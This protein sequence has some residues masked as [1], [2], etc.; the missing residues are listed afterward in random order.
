[1]LNQLRSQ[2][3]AL[4]SR[5]TRTQRLVTGALLAT[6]LALITAFTWW[7]GTPAYGVAFTGLSD[8][9]A[10]A[11]VEQLKSQSIP[12]KLQSGGVILVPASEV[13]DVRL[14]MANEGLPGN[15]TVGFELFNTNSLGLTEFT[16]KVNYQRALEGELARTI[17]SLTNV[18]SARV[19]L[20]IPE[21]AL[22]PDQ[23]KQTTASITVHLK[24]GQ[25]LNVNQVEAIT[26][27]VASSI[28][29]LDPANVVIVDS[30]GQLLSAGFQPGDASGVSLSDDQLAA[31]RQ[32]ETEVQT[33]VQDMLTQALGPNKA[34]VRVSAKLN[35]DQ[36]E[37]TAQT[38]DA[39]PVIRSSS[40][41]TETYTGNGSL[42]GG[43]PGTDT[44]LPTDTTP[45]YQTVITDTTGTNYQ[46][47]ET[48][49]NFEI[50]SVEKHTV[51]APGQVDRLSVS[52]LVD[53]IT[54]QATLDTLT[55]V[56]TMAAGADET[57]GDQI[58]VQSLAF[59]RTYYD[60]QT[61]DMESAEQLDL[62]I[63]IGA[64]IAAVIVVIA[65]LW[66]IQRM[67]SNLRLSAAND[68]WTPLLVSTGQQ[69]AL[70]AIGAAP[71]SAAQPGTAL[72]AGAETIAQALAHA[73]PDGQTA[74]P[75]PSRSPQPQTSPELER[76][77]RNVTR[78]VE[79]RPSIAAE[80]IR[81]WL[82]ED[83]QRK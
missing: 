1:M 66:F 3:A 9:D 29:G 28:E 53:G 77:Q 5:T 60:Q 62:W 8:A 81:L 57:R 68:V 4:W 37:T 30:E 24:L 63:R 67:L 32:Y 20:V 49:T 39:D 12:Y 18:E 35:W 61:A 26:H 40:V 52:V 74:Q 41:I 55:Q 70:P 46:R 76:A 45:T 48:T 36:I 64:I 21:A 22:F 44:N 11:I 14:S 80:V 13:Y 56:V 78:L 72:P 59:D 15:S 83:A 33:K 19:H 82:E 43:I 54:D 42:P 71:A 75:V 7:A 69:P 27:L 47:G 51:T 17:E 10:G 79:Q 25:K 16:Q 58:T 31:Q 73:A 38:F 65:V 34:V 50:S 23:Q 2:L 6:S